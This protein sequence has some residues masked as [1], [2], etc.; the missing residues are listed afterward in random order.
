[1]CVDECATGIS[2]VDGGVGLQEVF[3]TA[4]AET[5]LTSLRADD[6]RGHGLS[7]TKRVSHRQDRIADANLIRIA[8]LECRQVFRVDL[9]H[10]EVAGR[11]RTNQFGCEGAVVR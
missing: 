9:Q 8:E 10:C 3:K 7:D 4:I 11:V 6:S 1:A 2:A 5:G